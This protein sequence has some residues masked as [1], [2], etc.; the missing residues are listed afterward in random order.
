MPNKKL[1]STSIIKKTYE[2]SLKKERKK[3]LTKM[4]VLEIMIILPP[5]KKILTK[6]TSTAS[7]PLLH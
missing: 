4:M 5:S 2:N 7:I 3:I 6:L 1:T